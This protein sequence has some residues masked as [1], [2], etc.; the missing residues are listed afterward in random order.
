MSYST[1]SCIHSLIQQMS[2]EPLVHQAPILG[3]LGKSVTRLCPVGGDIPTVEE[4]DVN[5]RASERQFTEGCGLSRFNTAGA[6]ELL[7]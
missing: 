2:F 1:D 7:R 6:R 4:S 5:M 3:T